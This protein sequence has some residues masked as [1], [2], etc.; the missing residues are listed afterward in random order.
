MKAVRRHQLKNN[1]LAQQLETFPEYLKRNANKIMLIFTAALLVGFFVRY[2]MNA[3]AA[4]KAEV[5]QSLLA[6]RQGPRALR[7]YDAQVIPA[8]LLAAYRRDTVQQITTSI[9]TVLREAE[10]DEGAPMRA[11]ALVGRGDLNWTM[12]NLMQLSGAATQPS[13]GLPRSSDEYLRAAEDAYKQVLAEYG[14]YPI[15]VASAHFGLAAIAENRRDWATARQMYANI[16]DNAAMPDSF[17]SVA[18]RQ[19]QIMP[20]IQVPMFLSTYPPSTA[21]SSTP[22]TASST[23]R[24]A[25]N[26]P[27]SLT[28]RP[29]EATPPPTTMTAPAATQP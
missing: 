15:P 9:D 13:L 16:V 5:A 27:F 25:A 29:V 23:S 7:S 4:R 1:E 28:P 12:A 3:A 2:R 8:E 14:A 20:Q 24:P 19:I 21:P 18:R 10:G 22:A 11:E 26:D 6:V 17:K